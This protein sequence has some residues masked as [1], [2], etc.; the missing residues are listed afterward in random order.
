MKQVMICGVDC[1]PG[2][3]NCNGYCTGKCDAPPAA[4]EEQQIA[5]LRKDAFDKLTAAGKAWYEFYGALPVGPDRTWAAGVY[6]NL[7]RAT[8]RFG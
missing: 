2:D 8:R 6:E 7:H 5:A 4:T 1:R 3:A